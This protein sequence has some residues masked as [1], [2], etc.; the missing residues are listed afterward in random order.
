M[1][2][3]SLLAPI[4]LGIV[5]GLTEFIPVSST[6]HL[7]LAEQVL[8]YTGRQAKVLDVVIQVGAI[9]AICWLYR[10]RLW[11][12]A[13][14]MGIDAGARRFVVNVLLAF[15]PAAVVGAL[16][17]DFIKDVL[18]SPWVVAISLIIGGIAILAIERLLGRRP[19]SDGVEGIAPRRAFGVG[20]CQLLSLI[21]GVSR[22]GA[23][24]MGAMALGVER[25]TATEFSFFL[26]IP[27]MFG[28]AAFDLFKNRSIL[29]V[30]DA[31]P[32]LIGLLTSFLVA[33]VVVRWLVNFVG[34]HGFSIFAWYRM[35]LGSAMIVALARGWV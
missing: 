34:R 20:L 33:M 29:A 12:V 18:F 9:L 8:G 16:A 15:L 4:V 26:A 14:R 32:I 11:D 21:P 27:T 10:G 5:E 3:E 28:A 25:K 2:V 24:I 31:V 6:G 22:S 23:T 13:S 19:P 1:S 7:I 35:I 30:D 17:H